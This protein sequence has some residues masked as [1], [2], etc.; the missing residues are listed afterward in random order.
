MFDEFSEAHALHGHGVGSLQGIWL[1]L[2]SVQ[3]SFERFARSREPMLKSIPVWRQETMNPNGGSCRLFNA[4]LINS[5]V[6][7]RTINAI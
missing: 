4:P 2:S 3:P 7:F 1:I 5:L 6:I